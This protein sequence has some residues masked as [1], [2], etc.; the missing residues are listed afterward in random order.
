MI[1]GPVRRFLSG[2]SRLSRFYLFVLAA[3]LVFCPSFRAAGSPIPIYDV[4]A[5]DLSGKSFPVYLIEDPSRSLGVEEIASGKLKGRVASSRFIIP[6]VEANYWFCFT[7][8]NRSAAPIDRIIRFDEP[9]AD[10]AN[11]HYRA[12][13]G[14]RTQR[15]GLAAPLD[16][17]PMNHRNPV[18]LVTIQ[19]GQSKT[20]YLELHSDYGMLTIGAYVDRP[21]AFLSGEQWA[22]AGYFFY[23]GAA[24]ALILYNLF[25]CVSLRDRVYAYYVLHG[26][27]YVGWVFIYSGFDLHLGVDESLHYRINSI[28]NFILTFLAL[29]TRSLLQTGVNLPKIDKSL[30]II[31]GLAFASGTASFINIHF[32]QY[33]TFLALPSYCYLMFV[34]AYAWFKRIDLSRYYLTSMSLYFTGIILM[35]LMMMRALPYNLISRFFYLPGSL[36]E[37]TI[38][39]MALAHRFKMLQAQN[40]AYQQELIQNERMAKEQLEIEVSERTAELRRANR[41]LELI[42]RVDGLTGLYN[43]R[44]F[45]ETLAREWSRF[46]RTGEP[47]CLVMCDIDHF[48]KYNDAYGHLAGDECIKSVA[49]SIRRSLK[50]GADLAARYGGEEFTVVLPGTDLTGGESICREIMN[51][52]KELDIPHQGSEFGRVTLS[53]G[54]ATVRQGDDG[55]PENLVKLADQALYESKNQGR[56]RVSLAAGTKA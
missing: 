55:S 1:Q 44:T 43:R 22:T 30:L 10:T 38:F 17:R 23:F 13:G 28:T 51:R 6:S 5:D 25:L 27:C 54:V 45:D 39:S 8:V 52:L 53:F 32:Y 35:A 48:K 4:A 42:S 16:Q 20:I 15:A 9:F 24:C 3:L 47:L 19:P 18:F 7:L 46:R 11:I 29:F 26:L 36:A 33:L 31:A 50:R 21:T 12:D 2:A 34:G 40:A 56:N 41:R 37:L 14:W 49:E